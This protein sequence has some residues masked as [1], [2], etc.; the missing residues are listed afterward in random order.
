MLHS[1]NS[2]TQKELLL[3]NFESFGD[4]ALT[5]FVYTFTST[6]NWEKYLH[7]REDIHFKIMQI[8][9][10]NNASFAFPS[11]SVYVEKMPNS[12]L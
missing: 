8:V 7:I 2:I 12:N 1:H 6:S 3:V 9:E 11:Q 10:E 5:I 4:S